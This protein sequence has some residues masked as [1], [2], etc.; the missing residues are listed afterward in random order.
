MTLALIGVAA[1]ALAAFCFVGC[2]I[3]W[4]GPNPHALT[5][6]LG[7][8]GTISTL[9]VGAYCLGLFLIIQGF[10]TEGMLAGIGAGVGGLALCF[11]LTW[12]FWKIMGVD[13]KIVSHM[14]PVDVDGVQIAQRPA[15]DSGAG[16]TKPRAA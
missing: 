7:V 2:V 6:N 5:R 9:L 16:G 4:R 1:I 8:E 14:A 11:V 12:V 10:D 3:L 15:N 13:R